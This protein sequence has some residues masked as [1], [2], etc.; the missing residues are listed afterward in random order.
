MLI[1]SNFER[2]FRFT[3]IGIY[4]C[5]DCNVSYIG[6]TK[7]SFKV[8]TNGHKRAVKNQDLD[9]NEIAD[10]CWKNDLEMNWQERKVLDA[11]RSRNICICLFDLERCLR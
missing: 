11:E 5:K 2:S 3:N 1:C 10:H 6:E 7:R 9:K 8:R 4:P